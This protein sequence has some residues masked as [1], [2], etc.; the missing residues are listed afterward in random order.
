MRPP[1]RGGQWRI[2]G[3]SVRPPP[4]CPPAGPR[5]CAILP[6]RR[7]ARTIRAM[8]ALLTFPGAVARDPALHHWLDAQ[9]GELGDVA[10]AWFARM[11]RCG[12]NVRELLHDGLGT[13]CVA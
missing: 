9:P 8:P 13:L 4:A 5:S 1:G 7:R 3:G 2:C 6:G 10:R 12:A 11:R